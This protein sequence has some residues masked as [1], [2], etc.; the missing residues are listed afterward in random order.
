MQ[1]EG[2]WTGV[3]M[4]PA[5]SFDS[6]TLAALEDLQFRALTDGWGVYPYR[7]GSLSLLPQLL[8][9]TRSAGPGVFTGCF[10][11]GTMS[12]RQF[13]ALL[14]DIHE[15]APRTISF[16]EALCQSVPPV[17]PSLLRVLSRHGLPLYTRIRTGV[18]A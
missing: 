2:V 3:F 6:V 17:I 7:V 12:E 9:S 15:A 8:P 4:A 16:E 11:L 5:H 18:P 10:H 1:T 13:A 14:R